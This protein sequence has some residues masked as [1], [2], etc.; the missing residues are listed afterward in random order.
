MQPVQSSS[1]SRRKISSFDIPF[2]GYTYR[3]FDAMRDAFGSVNSRD[4]F[5]SINSR[6]AMRDAFG[7]VGSRDTLNNI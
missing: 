2:I 7:S 4:A 1:K 5:G 6:D 3:N